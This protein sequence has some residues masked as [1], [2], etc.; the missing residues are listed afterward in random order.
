VIACFYVQHRNSNPAQR[1]SAARYYYRV[2]VHASDK[3]T[4][5][6]AGQFWAAKG[7][8]N[9][10]RG[11]FAGTIELPGDCLRLDALVHE[12]IHA[13]RHWQRLSGERREEAQA[14]SLDWLVS[15][16]LIKL[17]KR[18]LPVFLTGSRARVNYVF[19]RQRRT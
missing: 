2:R 15:R 3:G 14:Y 4:E 17:L 5:G 1:R 8:R 16:I 6:N 12:S 13:V 11:R 9:A 18:R 10:R 19:Y 7:Q